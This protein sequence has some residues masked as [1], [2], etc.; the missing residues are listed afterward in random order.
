MILDDDGGLSPQQRH[1]VM[2]LIRA[3]TDPDE[4][5]GLFSNPDSLVRQ[6]AAS[7]FPLDAEHWT[8]AG[9]DPRIAATSLQRAGRTPMPEDLAA[10]LARGTDE[11]VAIQALMRCRD[12][13]LLVELATGAEMGGTR[14]TRALRRAIELGAGAAIL[15]SSAPERPLP[16]HYL[17]VLA[18]ESAD[19]EVLAAV[20]A[21]GVP[22]DE[23]L[24]NRHLPRRMLA[25]LIG[26][27]RPGRPDGDAASWESRLR[28][29]GNWFESNAHVRGPGGFE[30]AELRD[31]GPEGHLFYGVCA[32]LCLA[33]A[34]AVRDE[35]D[36]PSWVVEAITWALEISRG[37]GGS[38]DIYPRLQISPRRVTPRDIPK[39]F[40][41]ELVE[42]RSDALAVQ[43]EAEGRWQDLAAS[44]AMIFHALGTEKTSLYWLRQYGG[45]NG[46]DDLHVFAILVLRT[47]TPFRLSLPAS[48][49][50]HDR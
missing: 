47:S 26:S 4:V 23:L 32:P 11:K 42:A 25:D 7:W 14:A 28:D 33:A 21:S 49:K 34:V 9:V 40:R 17:E 31:C 35:T 13:E 16:P 20:R 24:A 41:S 8:A 39:I 30:S 37:A 2:D 50:T 36:A 19:P 29:A 27:I 6:L 15:A 18:R 10:A 22:Q 12:R 1:Q 44:A 46:Y 45:D 3:M 43:H 5:L 38:H 48:G